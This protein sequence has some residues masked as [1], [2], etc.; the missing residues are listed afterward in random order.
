MGNIV[1]DSV[2][3]QIARDE[4]RAS[5]FQSLSGEVIKVALAVERRNV[6]GGMLRIQY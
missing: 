3:G 2:C 6:P 4:C 1:R 5:E